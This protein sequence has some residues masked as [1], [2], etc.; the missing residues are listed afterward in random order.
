MEM[1]EAMERSGTKIP[2]EVKKLKQRGVKDFVIVQ[3]PRGN[4]H[5]VK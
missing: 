2:D 3:D 1:L 5:E 4:V